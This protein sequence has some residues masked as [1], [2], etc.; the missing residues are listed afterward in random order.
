MKVNM[1]MKF[2]NLIPIIVIFLAAASPVFAQQVCFQ[3]HDRT[4]FQQARVHQPIA[5]GK[6]TVCHNPHVARHSGLL[7]E[8]TDDLCY[9]CH[10]EEQKQFTRNVVHDPVR[11]GNCTACHDPH[12]ADQNALIKGKVAENCLSCHSGLPKKYKV[13]HQPYARGQCNFCHKP[14]QAD[15]YQLLKSPAEKICSKCHAR[16][17]VAGVHKNFPQAI[18][19]CLSCHSPHGS[20]RRAMIRNVKHEPF[21]NNCGACHKRGQEKISQETCLSCHDEIAGFLLSTHNHLTES[22]GNS[23]MNCHTPHAG[24]NELLLKAQQTVLCRN[25]HDDTFKRHAESKFVH[26]DNVKECNTCHDVHGT[27]A[28]AML[29]GDGNQVCVNCHETQ[30]QFTHPVGQKVIDPRNWQMTTCVTCHTPHG[31]DY[32]A[33]L[34]LSGDEALCLQC[35]HM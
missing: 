15:N 30:G 11:K 3:C 25:C 33:E 26:T 28:F 1:P 9:S 5:A 19:G 32:K 34:K 8:Q 17:E 21:A 31:S 18:K 29:K 13:T 6:C 20:N 14:H 22:G 4:A 10:T 23:C 7:H 35:H 27:N 24:D 12:S 16:N 2:I